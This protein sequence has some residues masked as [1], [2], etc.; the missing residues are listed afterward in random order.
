MSDS[1]QPH[2]RQPIR[3]HC[4]WDS[5]AKNTGVGCHF[6]LHCMK[7]KWFSRVQLFATPWTAAYQAPPSMGFFQARILECDAV[8]FSKSITYS[9]LK[10]PLRF[11]V[12]WPSQEAIFTVM[13]AKWFSDS[14]ILIFQNMHSWNHKV[15]PLITSWASQANFFNDLCLG[16]NYRYLIH[17]YLESKDIWW[18]HIARSMEHNQVNSQV[19]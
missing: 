13:V 14:S 3:L 9:S 8:A 17:S 5:P 18:S 11:N 6:L 19:A 16:C 12:H 4:L 15:N 10:C 2:R 1:V 7:V